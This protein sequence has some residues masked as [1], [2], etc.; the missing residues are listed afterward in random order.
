MDGP[1]AVSCCVPN[2]RVGNPVHACEDVHAGT[3][4]AFDPQELRHMLHLIFFSPIVS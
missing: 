2:P 1:R 4:L 3:R